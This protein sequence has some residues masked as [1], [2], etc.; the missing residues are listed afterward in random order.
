MQRTNRA[1]RLAL[2]GALCTLA[3]IG[4]ASAETEA[5]A[6]P[7][8]PLW[9]LRLGGTALYSP[10]YPGAE[11]SH[12]RGI[13]APLFVYRGERI[14][15]GADEPNSVARA[16]AVE[17]KRFEL[18]LSANATFSA[19]SDDND[20]RE[21]MPDL[22]YMVEL[23][24][25]ATFNIYDETNASGGRS[26]L[27]FLFPLRFAGATDFGGFDDLGYVVEPTLHYRR[28]FSGEHNRSFSAALGATWAS[29]GV[30]DYYYEVA[31]QYVRADRP[32]YDAGGGYLGAYFQLST[33]REVR[34]GLN[35]YLTYRLREFAGAENRDLPLHLADE[36]HAVSVSAVWTLLRSSRPARN[37]ED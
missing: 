17:T 30:Q 21:G 15:I 33:K 5:V 26:R 31:P 28:Q 37:A 9:E 1:A 7:A 14:R 11:Q 34:E 12:W 6:A 36:T 29:E 3:S 35:L 4:A 32:A 20:A 24:P 18:D 27:R 2:T 23:G 16:I 13:G 19:D 10:D 22:D 8:Q 25:Q